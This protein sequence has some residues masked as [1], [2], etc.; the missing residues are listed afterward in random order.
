MA[1]A[2]LW[3]GRPPGP[4]AF[5][6]VSAPANAVVARVIHRM[7]VILPPGVWRAWR[8]DRPE[9]GP[10][11]PMPRSFPAGQMEAWPV[12]RRVNQRG[13]EAPDCITPV[14]PEQGE[15]DLSSGE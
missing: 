10:L 11:L 2:A 14:I 4:C 7:P 15:L 13:Y 3:D 5:T 1:L 6:L 9:A 8:D 12:T